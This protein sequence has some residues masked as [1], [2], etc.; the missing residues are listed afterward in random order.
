MT[1]SMPISLMNMGELA[2]TGQILLAADYRWPYL[3]HQ[4]VVNW[5]KSDL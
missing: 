5:E 1:S 4:F 2:E 3:T